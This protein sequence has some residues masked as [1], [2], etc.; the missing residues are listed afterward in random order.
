MSARF[1]ILAFLFSHLLLNASG[2]DKAI[3]LYVKKFAP[4]STTIQYR[5]GE[6]TVPVKLIQYGDKKDIVYINLHDDEQTSVNAA[7]V[8]LEQ[9]GGFMIK[10]EN[11]KKRNIRFRLKGRYYTFDPNR[12]F[13]AEGASQSLTQFKSFSKEAVAEV[14]KFGERILQFMPENPTCIIALHNNTKGRFGVNSYLPGA[15]READ[16]RLVFENPDESPDDIFLTTDSLLYHNLSSEKYNTIWQDNENVRRDGSLSVYCGERNIRYVNCETEHGR[17]NQYLTMLM[18]LAQHIDRINPD[19]DVYG[20]TVSMPQG[21]S[22][23]SGSNIYFGDK[24]IGTLKTAE[25]RDGSDE[26]RGKLEIDKK[27]RLWS[28][29]DFFFFSTADQPRIEM[30]IDPTREKKPFNTSSELIRIIAR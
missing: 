27:Y 23:P 20:Y 8:L 15:E 22:F 24:L 30:R 19:A 13:S 1:I 2:Q 11:N 12:M 4:K 18:A 16:A 25:A 29:M 9:E 10:I 6:T 17:T 28:N 3:P 7:R 26:I 21:V 5:L 14:A